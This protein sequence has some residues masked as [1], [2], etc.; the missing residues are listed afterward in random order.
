MELE[1]LVVLPVSPYGYVKVDEVVNKACFFFHFFCPFQ[2]LSY[3]SCSPKL[4]GVSF[5][6][7]TKYT[8][9]DILVF[10]RKTSLRLKEFSAQGLLK[11]DTRKR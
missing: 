3:L 7:N 8:F 5:M 10:F 1:P 4:D 6:H 9:S 2:S 11:P